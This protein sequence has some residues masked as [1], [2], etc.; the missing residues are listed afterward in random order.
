MFYSIAIRKDSRVVVCD[1][2]NVG[3]I[4][5]SGNTYHHWV[6]NNS[7]TK[8]YKIDTTG[9]APILQI[10]QHLKDREELCQC[11]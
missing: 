7:G 2:R 9:F 10:K 8:Q 3:Y 11:I 4:S 6:G 1:G 5:A